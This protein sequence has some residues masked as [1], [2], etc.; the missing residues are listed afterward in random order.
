[1]QGRSRILVSGVKEDGIKWDSTCV[2]GRVYKGLLPARDKQPG[3][4]YEWSEIEVALKVSP[5][6][7]TYLE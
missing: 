1:M 4:D 3:S 2:I 7:S 5:V 6:A